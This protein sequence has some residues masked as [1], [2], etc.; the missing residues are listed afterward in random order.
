MTKTISITCDVCSADVTEANRYEFHYIDNLMH[1]FCHIHYF[2]GY[3]HLY[4]FINNR[5]KNSS[6]DKSLLFHPLRNNAEPE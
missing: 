4:Q 1:K 5:P 6:D 2:C 3:E